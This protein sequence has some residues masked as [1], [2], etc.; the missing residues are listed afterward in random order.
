MVTSPIGKS[1]SRFWPAAA[2]LCAAAGAACA[3][4]PGRAERPPEW[5]RVIT[6]AGGLSNFYQVTPTLYR[7]AQP[8]KEGLVYLAGGA[9]PVPGATPIRTVLSLRAFHDDASLLPA[10]S[11]VQ[12]EEIRFNTWHPENEDIVKF[13]RV[14]TT[15]ELQPVLVHCQHGSDRTGTMVA[16]YRIVVQGWSK[17]AALDE[18]TE[19]GYGFHPLWRNL[20][21]Y[22]MQLDVDALKA[23]LAKQGPWR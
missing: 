5:A 10:G 23:E 3:V 7:S 15:P 14:V 8:S 18:M 21:R 12:Y 1:R 17:E 19:G 11:T 6:G 2:L 13:L 16:L 20:R 22:V 4:Q 9:V